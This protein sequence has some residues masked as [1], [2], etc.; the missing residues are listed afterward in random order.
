MLFI[1]PIPEFDNSPKV[2]FHQIY[3]EYNVMW[4][5][6][7]VNSKPEILIKTPLEHRVPLP[8]TQHVAIGK[9]FFAFIR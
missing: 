2:K 6:L 1:G 3:I 8:G 9:F 7:P 4:Q 5:Y